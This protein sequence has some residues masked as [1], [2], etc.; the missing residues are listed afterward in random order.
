MECSQ[1]P[2]LTLKGGKSYS[3]VI[4]SVSSP[5]FIIHLKVSLVFHQRSSQ[6]LHLEDGEFN[7]NIDSLISYLCF[8]YPISGE[9]FYSDIHSF[10]AGHWMRV[11]EGEMYE[12]EGNWDLRDHVN[13][14]DD[15]SVEKCIKNVKDLLEKSVIKRMQSDVPWVHISR[16]VDSSAV[17]SNNGQ[18]C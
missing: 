1:S 17:A 9:T 14:D 7:L 3:L 12:E 10:P 13:P 2:F 15:S 11:V 8:R 4:A 16:G 6:V 18:E 5:Y